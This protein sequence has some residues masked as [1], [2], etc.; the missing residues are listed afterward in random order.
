VEKVISS[1]RS[2]YADGD[3][4]IDVFLKNYGPYAQSYAAN[5]ESDGALVD[6]QVTIKTVKE[7]NRYDVTEVVATA[8][9]ILEITFVN[10]DAMQHNLLIIEPG[11][12][13][14]V[15]ME[16][17]AFAKAKYAAEKNYV[18]DMEEILHVIPIM[19]PGEEYKLRIKV[20]EKPGDYPFVCTF[21]GHWKT[22]NGVIKVTARTI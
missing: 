16:G 4:I 19:N 13:R 7:Q 18:P 3:D 8:G 15:G 10:D 2:E 22:M 20:P 12:L 14:R 11:S 6:R 5:L 21:P 9:E 17:E 1:A